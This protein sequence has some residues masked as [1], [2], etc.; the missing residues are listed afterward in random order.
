MKYSR[1][2][3]LTIVTDCHSSGQWVSECAKFL[4]E[5]GVKAC[6][7]SAKQKGILLKIYASCHQGQDAAELL[8]IIHGISVENGIIYF[9]RNTVIRKNQITMGFDFTELRC[10]TKEHEVCSVPEDNSW[11]EEL[12][13]STSKSMDTFPNSQKDAL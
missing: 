6:G 5:Q 2:R 8:H 4:D 13:A 11:L 10:G 7:H 1:G 9:P 12:N 3:P